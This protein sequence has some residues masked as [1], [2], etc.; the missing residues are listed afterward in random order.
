[1]SWEGNYWGP[2][3]T[4]ETAAKK[5]ESSERMPED[6]ISFASNRHSAAGRALA[7][8]LIALKK[9]NLKGAYAWAR[10]GLK[11]RH[12]AVWHVDKACVW[13]V[14][15][16]EASPSELDVSLAVWRAW[17]L[18]RFGWRKDIIRWIMLVRILDHGRFEADMQE[19]MPHT[20]AFLISHAIAFGYVERTKE[21]VQTI[22]RLAEISED[23]GQTAQASRVWK[24]AWRHYCKLFGKN[25]DIAQVVHARALDVAQKSSADQVVKLTS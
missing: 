18:T 16:N 10:R 8:S 21:R 17:T 7:E 15:L 5:F 2:N 23:I 9:R 1:M 4:L 19:E 11:L 12:E 14:Y 20:R 13:D 24:H 3:G 22:E 6:F 25:S